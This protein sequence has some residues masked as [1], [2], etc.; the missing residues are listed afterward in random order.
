MGGGEPVQF[1]D[2]LDELRSAWSACGRAGA[3]RTAALAYFSL[4]SDAS[5]Q[6][7]HYLRRYYDFPLDAGDRAL[8]EGEAESLAAVTLRSTAL[9]AQTVV[10]VVDAWQAVDCDELILLPC[11][12]DPDQVDLLADAL[13]GRLS[14]AVPAGPA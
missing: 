2:M 10:G 1:R 14:R 7:E 9:D 3:P 4:G 12:A 8:V 13:G 11:G 6:A 5:A